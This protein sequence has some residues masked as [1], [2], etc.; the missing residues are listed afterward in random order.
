MSDIRP[1]QINISDETL[2]SVRDR[3]ANYPWHE[4]PNDGGWAYGAN[5]DY[6]KELCDYWVT[7]YDWR[8]HETEL[9][10]FSHFVAPVDGIDIHF[11][12]EKG[13]GPAPMPLIIS[14]G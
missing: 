8:K 3:V 12:H 14:H 1:F 9:N 6:M 13:S 4:M 2:Q 11:I 7:T 5:L 10:K